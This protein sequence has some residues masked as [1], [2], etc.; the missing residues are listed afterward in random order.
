M[1]EMNI[2]RSILLACSRGPTRLFRQQVGQAWVGVSRRFSRA[3][4]VLV[5]PGDVLI[6]QA[7]PFNVG[8]PGLSDLG[9]WVTRDGVAVYTAIEVKTATGRVSPE[10]QNFIDVVN[11]AGGIAGVARSVEDAQR[12]LGR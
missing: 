5:Q 10:Q 3:E 8:M 2:L 6:R 4:T 9:G 11:A 12:L 7:R 1:S